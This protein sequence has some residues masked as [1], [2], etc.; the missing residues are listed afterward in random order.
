ML[1]NKRRLLSFLLRKWEQKEE[2]QIDIFKFMSSVYKKS[3]NEQNSLNIL[4]N[5]E[6]RYV[7]LIA[8][9]QKS[10]ES[11]QEEKSFLQN[12]VLRPKVKELKIFKCSID[13]LST[14]LTRDR[15]YT[16]RFQVHII[17]KNLKFMKNPISAEA[18][19]SKEL[20]DFNKPYYF[21]DG[22]KLFFKLDPD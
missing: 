1:R 11:W 20:C 12:S 13:L 8:T 18:F 6:A 14:N 5:P 22:S 17:L 4:I 10:K 9:F 15:G 21:D 2:V 3:Q 19:I 16:H 7:P